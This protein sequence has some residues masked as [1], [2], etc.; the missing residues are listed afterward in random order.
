MSFDQGT[1]GTVTMTRW[2]GDQP[3]GEVPGNTGQWKVTGDKT[4]EITLKRP[5]GACTVMRHSRS[6][7][8]GTL[9]V[10]SA[11]TLRNGGESSTTSVYR[12]IKGEPRAVFG[13]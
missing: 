8:G 9:T 6:D 2:S 4:F 3:L 11:T 7:D 10:T 13:E 5:V 12:R 1:D